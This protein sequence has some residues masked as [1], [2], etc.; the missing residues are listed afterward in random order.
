[1]SISGLGPEAFYRPGSVTV[2]TING[3]TSVH[4][5]P[6]EYIWQP[7]VLWILWV[8]ATIVCITPILGYHAWRAVTGAQRED[9]HCY[10]TRCIH[11]T[12][13]GLISISAIGGLLSAVIYNSIGHFVFAMVFFFVI[14]IYQFLQAVTL[15]LVCRGFGT[16]RDLLHWA[17]VTWFMLTATLATAFF[18]SWT[19][20]A[21]MWTEWAGVIL[22]LAYFVGWPASFYLRT[23]DD[24]LA[25]RESETTPG[26]DEDIAGGDIVASAPAN[27]V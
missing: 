9:S 6:D 26:E 17:V 12:S 5:E 19:C 3:V 15:A 14:I 1:M 22:V 24:E 23:L 21:A 25:G 13:V 18:V 8:V 20:G 7:Y 27:S 4:R 2:S 10:D 16:G 11:W